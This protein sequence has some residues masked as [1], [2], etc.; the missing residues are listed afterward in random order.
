MTLPL[1][2]KIGMLSMDLDDLKTTLLVAFFPFDYE[3]KSQIIKS[4]V[5]PFVISLDHPIA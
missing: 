2:G 4:G 1:D 5:D 3:R